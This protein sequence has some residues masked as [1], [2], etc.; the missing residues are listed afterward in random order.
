MWIRCNKVGAVLAAIGCVALSGCAKSPE[1]IFW[2]SCQTR[3]RDEL[4]APRSAVFPEKPLYNIVLKSGK[5][6]IA[7][8]VDSQNSFGAMLRTDFQCMKGFG[9]PPVDDIT[10]VFRNDS[11]LTAGGSEFIIQMAAKNF[12]FEVLDEHDREQ[13]RSR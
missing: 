7:S 6:L 12:M 10:V 4:K 8:S 5:S 3:V 9:T 13:G 11:A 2:A 1:Q